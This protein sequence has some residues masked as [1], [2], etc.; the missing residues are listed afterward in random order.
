MSTKLSLDPND[1]VL[2]IAE[3]GVNHDGSLG[4]AMELVYAAH[5]VGADAVKVQLFHADRL[6]HPSSRFAEYQQAGVSDATPT[7]MLRRYEL[8]EAG[9]QR[10]AVEAK[11]LGLMFLATPF[12]PGDVELIES[13][14]LPAVKIASPDIVNKP[15]LKRAA[16]LGKPLLISTGAATI[17]EIAAASGWLNEWNAQFALLH[18]VSSYPVPVESAHLGWISDLRRTFGVPVGY[19]DHTTEI[20]AGALAVAAGAKFI[21]KH[22][23]LDRYAEGPDHAASFDVGQFSEY[24]RQIRMAEAMVGIGSK[25]VQ[26]IEQDVRQVSRQSLVLSRAISA[27]EEVGADALTVQRPG[28]GVPAGEID[29]FIGRRARRALR[30]GEMASWDMVA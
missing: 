15:L 26:E 2:I 3:I 4:Q 6:M 17:D 28:T 7:D 5:R 8:E 20:C 12:S 16:T 22:L 14:D 11:E 9:I 1:S 25:H 18:C 23:T 13:L 10:L 29:R 24:V 27:G 21:E 19:S 30:P